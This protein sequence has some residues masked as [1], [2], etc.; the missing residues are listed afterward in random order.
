LTEKGAARH[1]LE[2]IEA[3]VTPSTLCFHPQDNP[4]ISIA[5][6]D[7]T[8]NEHK[9]VEVRSFPTIKYYKAGGDVVDF[10]VSLR[11]N[12]KLGRNEIKN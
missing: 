12:A 11:S 5:K 6:M 4:E 9:E 2:T 7:A 3:C 1:F 10:E 8:A